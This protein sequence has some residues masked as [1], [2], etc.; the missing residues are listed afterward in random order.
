MTY[1]YTVLGHIRHEGSDILSAY[2]TQESA[3]SA[4]EAREA[5]DMATGPSRY[6]DY[7]SVFEVEVLP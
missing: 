7:Y 6:Y 1:I 2:L 5:T 3:D 4:A